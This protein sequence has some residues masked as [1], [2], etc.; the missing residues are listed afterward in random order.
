MATCI[1]VD[2]EQQAHGILKNYVS[3]CSG[4]VILGH[5]YNAIEANT[6]L[7]QHEVD[8]IL[9]D[10]QMPE[11]TGLEF[12]KQLRNAPQI[13]L[14]TAYSDFA[15]DGFDLGVVDYL[16]KPIPYDRFEKALSKLDCIKQPSTVAQHPTLKFR[17]NGLDKEFQVETIQYFQSM[18]N[19]IKILTQDKSYLT[20]LTMAEL[21]RAVPENYFVR[22]HKSFMVP[23]K[24]IKQM[25]K[26]NSVTIE[27]VI[28]PVGRTF[29]N[30][31]KA[32]LRY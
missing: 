16:L 28:I 27:N 15:L 1:I 17:V 29:K 19:Y 23:V 30:V 18:G 9:L 8:F 24:A 21:G 14:T 25:T 12:I 5:A 26:P 3:R 20:T 2:D 22:I 10:I 11:I 7:S 31:V 32:H 4:I 6:L 13:I